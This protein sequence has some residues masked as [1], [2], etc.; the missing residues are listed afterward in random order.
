ME[1]KLISAKRQ[2]YGLLLLKHPNHYTP[3]EQDMA[4]A[5]AHDADIQ[6]ILQEGI[7]KIKEEAK[8]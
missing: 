1:S 5:L 6:K 4:F 3:A 2:L 8:Q 7:N